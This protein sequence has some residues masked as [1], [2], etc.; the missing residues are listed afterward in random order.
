MNSTCQL[1]NV[2]LVAET[3]MYD[4]EQW[5]WFFCFLF[6]SSFWAEGRKWFLWT[7]TALKLWLLQLVLPTVHSKLGH[8]CLV[9]GADGA[10][11]SQ[12]AMGREDAGSLFQCPRNCEHFLVLH[13]E[14]QI[15]PDPVWTHQCFSPS[16]GPS[17][18]CGRKNW[19]WFR[20]SLCKV[21]PSNS[22]PPM[23]FPGR[24]VYNRPL[25]PNGFIYYFWI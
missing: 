6:F 23:G 1:D 15:L 11:G 24:V 10:P 5:N 20:I 13:L 12:R 25:S 18:Q 8:P 22:Q 21:F 3:A 4:E 16:I 19:E 7:I 9:V 17:F 14:S 2:C